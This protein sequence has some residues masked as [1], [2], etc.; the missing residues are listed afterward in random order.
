MGFDYEKKCFTADNH[1]MLPAQ[2]ATLVGD[3]EPNDVRYTDYENIWPDYSRRRKV[4]IDLNSEAY[5][6]DEV[7]QILDDEERFDVDD[8][9]IIT[10]FVRIINTHD[11]IVVDYSAYDYLSWELVLDKFIRRGNPVD[12]GGPAFVK[13]APVIHCI[14]NKQELELAEGPLA[15][16]YNI[17]LDDS[18]YQYLLEI[19]DNISMLEF[20][21]TDDDP[22]DT[23]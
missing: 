18:E 11:G 9:D 21:S 16:S 14:F 22:E 4:W 7:A 2:V 17:V 1:E 5:T 15:E 20:D 3:L 13:K 6:F 12:D 19:Q 8:P 10:G 23:D